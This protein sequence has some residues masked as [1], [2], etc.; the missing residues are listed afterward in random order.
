MIQFVSSIFNIRY[1]QKYSNV[2]NILLSYL[3]QMS[4]ASHFLYRTDIGLNEEEAKSTVRISFGKIHRLKD[5]ETV[6]NTIHQIMTKHS[7]EFVAHEI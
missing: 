7:K 6:V 1:C 2:S 3:T 5:I 4:T